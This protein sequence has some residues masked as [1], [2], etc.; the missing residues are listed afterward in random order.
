M[1]FVTYTASLLF[2]VS[3]CI[4]VAAVFPIVHLSQADWKWLE[5][6]SKR[7]ESRDLAKLPASV[8][9]LCA[10][11][12]GRLAAPGQKWE[13]TDFIRDRTL[14]RKRLVWFIRQNSRYLV[15]Y[16]VGGSGYNVQ[17]LIADVTADGS[18]KCAWHATAFKAFENYAE[19]LAAVNAN[20]RLRD[21][22]CS[23][24]GAG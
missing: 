3:C 10:D 12:D 14:P 13:A 8:V 23:T 1:R 2:G 20:Q 19:F 7:K 15:H 21:D 17:T 4:S 22:S 11:S 24:S 5:S 9:A 6:A 16:E 18:A